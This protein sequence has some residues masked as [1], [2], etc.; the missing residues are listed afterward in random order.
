[1][2]QL[3]NAAIPFFGGVIALL[4]GFR[5]IG[6]KKGEDPKFDEWHARFGT[7]LKVCGGV[8]IL[9]AIFYFALGGGGRR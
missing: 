7:V 4:I 3:I 8:L 5:I 2:A 1:M 9:L 6:K